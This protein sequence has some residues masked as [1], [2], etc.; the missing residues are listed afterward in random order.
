MTGSNKNKTW[1]RW[2]NIACT[3]VFFSG[4]AKPALAQLSGP[5]MNNL[6]GMEEKLFFKS[7]EDTD[8]PESR[9]ARLEKRIFGDASEG[10]LSDRMAK[11]G[12]LIKPDEKKPEVKN[13]APQVQATQP[14]RQTKPQVSAP[15]NNQPP[16]P[17]E[18]RRRVRLAKE[19][20]V[21]QLQSE[22]VEL[23]KA[24]RGNE[25]LEKFEQ[26]VR[27]APDFAE[28]HFS[29]GVIFEAKQD[30]QNALL[31]YQRALDLVPGKR[32]YTEAVNLVSKKAHTS[33]ANQEKKAEL[34]QLAEQAS[35]AYRT[36]Q[37]QSALQLYKELDK[38][39][40][41][42]ALVKYNIGT[43]YLAL[44]NPVEA[45]EY[46]KL[47][48]KLKPDEPRYQDA[49]QK[50]SNNLQQDTRARQQAESAWGGGNSG[51]N[52]DKPGKKVKE[53]K[54]KIESTQTFQNNTP[55]DFS[56]VSNYRQP[57]QP[58]PMGTPNGNGYNSPMGMPG[59]NGFNSPMAGGGGGGTAS[60]AAFGIMARDGANGAEIT[61]VGAA[62]KALR[63]GLSRGDIVKA[64]DGVIINSTAD[65]NN[66]LMR[67]QPHE[68]AQ[69]I[70][71]RKGQIGQFV[72][73]D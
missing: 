63:A 58:M 8:K 64:V 59:G 2:L 68:A 49:V 18:M 51:N 28:A 7:Y 35:T 25:A 32:E 24:R 4:Q 5:E 30:Y 52:Q 6:K 29:L 54:R 15:R 16:D 46:F 27:I 61:S 1:L 60:S 26:V 19:E 21:A 39:A 23:W 72:L 50:L 3:V 11:L 34:K 56:Q 55:A 67:K 10:P 53:P 47:A 45:L 17:E 36:G 33:E 40:P 9:V 66:V 42:E 62:S 37:F 48:A 31:S 65:L 43:I 22:A 20:E 41:K 14:V 57:Q 13:T 12:T 73:S 44:K 69:F 70:I 71:Q 38:K